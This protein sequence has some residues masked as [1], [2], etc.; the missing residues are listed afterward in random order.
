MYSDEGVGVHL[1]KLLENKYRFTSDNHTINFIDGG[2]LA[3]FLMHI[4]TE[5]DHLLLLDCID[6]NDAKVGDVYFFDFNKMPKAV[7]WSGSAHE[8]EML[9]TLQMLDLVG[10]RPQ[11]YI[12]GIIPKR[13]EPMSFE[14]SDEIQD[15]LL[16]MENQAIKHIKSLG[17]SCE[18]ISN[19][20]IRDIA[21]ELK[22]AQYDSGI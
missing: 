8:V 1:C 15:G 9:Q 10:D 22:K 4:I 7:S 2:T 12:L 20:S 19:L 5:Y 16:T 6:A 13:I 3:H 18:Q 21:N 14:I 17:F 11:T